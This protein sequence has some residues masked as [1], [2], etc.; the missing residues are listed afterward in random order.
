MLLR[1][2]TLSPSRRHG[3]VPPLMGGSEVVGDSVDVAEPTM[4]T[5]MSG[6]MFWARAERR[7]LSGDLDSLH[8]ALC[9]HRRPQGRDHRRA[10]DGAASGLGEAFSPRAY[11][12]D[13][14]VGPRSRRWCSCSRSSASRAAALRPQPRSSSSRA[15][16]MWS[17]TRSACPICAHP[18][19]PS[20]GSPVSISFGRC[21]PSRISG[22]RRQ[23]CEE[24]ARA[25]ARFPPGIA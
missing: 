25:H 13:R 15:S 11:E 6:E 7:A 3:M 17:S 16:S 14:G 22:R 5:I 8:H 20:A 12:H 10:A 21:W 9:R 24:S 2:I 18:P 4:E 19:M 23:I 1:L